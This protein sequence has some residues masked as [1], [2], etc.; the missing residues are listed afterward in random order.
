ME[1]SNRFLEIKYLFQKTNLINSTLPII[2][3]NDNNKCEEIGF[4]KQLNFKTISVIHPLEIDNIKI[5]NVIIFMNYIIS[6]YEIICKNFKT[7]VQNLEY[8]YLVINDKYKFNELYNEIKYCYRVLSWNDDRQVIIKKNF[9][10]F[11]PNNNI[12]YNF[13]IDIDNGN[14]LHSH[15]SGY[16]KYSSLIQYIKSNMNQF[17][18]KNKNN[19]LLIYY[20]RFTTNITPKTIEKIENYI[21]QKWKNINSVPDIML[22]GEL[23]Y[24]VIKDVKFFPIYIQLIL[25]QMKNENIEKLQLRLK[26]GSVFKNINKF[27]SY[28]E[29][30]NMIQK[31]GKGKIQIIIQTSK[32][33]YNYEKYF[34]EIEK[35]NHPIV[36]G[37]DL[38]GHENNCK[39]L[40]NLNKNR[41]WYL[42]AG[43]GLEIIN[44]ENLKYAIPISER[45]GHGIA[46]L[47]QP[48]DTNKCFEFTPIGYYLTNILTIEQ[49]ILLFSLPINFTINADDTNKYFDLDLNE[50][51][52][53]VRQLNISRN[54]IELAIE[55]SKIYY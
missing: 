28:S 8:E 27:I 32:N 43:E 29:E 31:Y 37:Y 9:E 44:I 39:P 42:H 47:R 20:K 48:I 53:F 55:N 33:D 41:N 22:L 36:I 5:K 30:L 15:F 1:N 24:F 7:F 52:K 17:H 16:V 18:I 54:I 2:I 11:I 40:S 45:I 23:F 49:I 21:H 13:D 10:L 4:L 19:K 6:K 14:H 50:N 35:L 3:I 34:K 26:I 46:Y 25:E 38:V 51:L 12:H